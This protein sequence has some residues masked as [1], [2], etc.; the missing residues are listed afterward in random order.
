[1]AVRK[2][3]ATSLSRLRSAITNGS[4]V[5]ANCDHRSATMRRFR[6]LIQL[7]VGDL[8][9]EG[10]ISEAE[11]SLVR[12]AAM[13]TLQLELL[14]QR[15]AQAGGEATSSQLTDYQRAANSLRRILETL[16]LRRRPRDVTPS[17]G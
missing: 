4:A 5:L 8:G 15:F 14:E 2:R 9:G 11:R 13:L 3:T 1:M 16:G 10:N 17:V 12:R 7:H 6:D